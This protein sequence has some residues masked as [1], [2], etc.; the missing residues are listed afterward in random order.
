MICSVCNNAGEPAADTVHTL[1]PGDDTDADTDS[2]ME[3]EHL[4]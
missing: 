3:H 1:A 2:D 4:H